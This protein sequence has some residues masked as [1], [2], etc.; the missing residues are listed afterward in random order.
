M[1]KEALKDLVKF[2]RSQGIT[3][4]KSA[5]IELNLSEAP[6]KKRYRKPSKSEETEIKHKVEQMKSIMI[7]SDDEL[8]DIV[9]PLPK[10]EPEG[11]IPWPIPSNQ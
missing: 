5:D 2:L 3:H 4:Y 6:P 9:F 1:T 7:L 10:E 8:L 11:D